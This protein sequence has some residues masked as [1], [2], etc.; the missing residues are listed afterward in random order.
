MTA[1]RH[2]F[3]GFNFGL[4]GSMPDESLKFKW[5]NKYNAC[6]T[7]DRGSISLEEKKIRDY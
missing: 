3:E 1:E 7:A 5:F 6:L 4:I 2:G